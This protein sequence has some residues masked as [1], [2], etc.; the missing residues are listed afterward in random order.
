MPRWREL[1]SR[2]LPALVSSRQRKR[3]FCWGRVIRV[4]FIFIDQSLTIPKI[5]AFYQR[6]TCV[7]QVPH[8]VGHPFPAVF[9]RRIVYPGH[10]YRADVYQLSLREGDLVSESSI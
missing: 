2:D 1:L 4:S 3:R 9:D 7:E 5:E 8:L 10:I 6:A